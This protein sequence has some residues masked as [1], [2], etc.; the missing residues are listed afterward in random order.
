MEFYFLVCVHATVS[1][2][3][4]STFGEYV[5]VKSSVQRNKWKAELY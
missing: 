3:I 2:M 5:Y 4:W 1:A